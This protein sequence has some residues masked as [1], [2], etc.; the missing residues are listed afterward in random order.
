MNLDPRKEQRDII[1]A[2]QMQKGMFDVCVTTY[3]A[4]HYVPELR[5]QNEYDWYLL[6]FDEAHKLKNSES[7]T[8]KLSRKIDATRRLLLTGTPL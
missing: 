7:M 4:L 2:N 3:E 5:K 1:L 6:V 8:I